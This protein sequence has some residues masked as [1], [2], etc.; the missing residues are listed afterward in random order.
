M[1]FPFLFL[2]FACTT[3]S[4]FTLP[5]H[6]VTIYDLYKYQSNR[7]FI[8]RVIKIL[9]TR[10]MRINNTADSLCLYLDLISP[11][12]AVKYADKEVARI[13]AYQY[14]GSPLYQAP[15]DRYSPTAPSFA[16]TGS[17]RNTNASLLPS[18]GTPGSTNS[19]ATSAPAPAMP[20]GFSR[21]YPPTSSSRVHPAHPATA[22]EVFAEAYTSLPASTEHDAGDGITVFLPAGWTR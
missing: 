15:A 10:V 12:Q 2:L 14:P 7:E 13:A 1:K 11:T 19:V 17:T 3:S 16:P 5:G 18:H 21:T 9:N 4:L 8:A 20:A 6:K 22:N